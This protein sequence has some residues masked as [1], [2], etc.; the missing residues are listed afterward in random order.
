MLK[1]IIVGIFG[2][3]VWAAGCA[4]AGTLVPVIPVAGSTE[5]YVS[6]INDNNQ[7]SGWYA[8]S[9]GSEHAFFGTLDGNYTTFDAGK[10]GSVAAKI[11]NSG[12]IV[13][14][15]NTETT[16]G[17]KLKGFERQP[18][19][20][21]KKVTLK[22]KQAGQVTG[23]ENGH[24]IFAG[25][26]WNH[27]ETA[28]RA[29]Y[30]K[31]GKFTE[32]LPGDTNYLQPRDLNR[33][34]TVVGLD[35]QYG[36][37]FVLQNGNKTEFRYPPSA[38]TTYLQGINDKGVATGYGTNTQGAYSFLY[39]T[40]TATITDFTVDGATYT[41][42]GRPNNAG[43]F[44]VYADEVPYIYCPASKS[45]CPTGIEIRDEKLLRSA[46]V[47]RIS[48]LSAKP[49]PATRIFSDGRWFDMRSIPSH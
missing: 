40:K 48:P 31:N 30:G 28:E 37:A 1:P 8:D 42:L 14:Y 47:A 12:Y 18:N 27:Q 29:Y 45:K 5:M 46:K 16:D 32:L 33:D 10:N 44:P 3:F 34:K 11:N 7:I 21:I 35:G 49:R 13:G 20:T 9:T 38:I 36:E 17:T 19:G 23:I 22:G 39:N 41:Y 6:S 15:F 24:D 26:D 2:G 25:S 4:E 43:W